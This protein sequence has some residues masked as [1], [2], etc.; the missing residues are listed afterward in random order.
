MSSPFVQ[1]IVVQSGGSTGPAPS[2]ALPAL[3][4]FFVPGLGQL[5]QGRFLAGIF[6]FVLNIIAAI[7]MLAVV[8]FVLLPLV[9]LLCIVDAAKYKPR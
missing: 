3:A 4:N 1:T 6:W 5:I 2:Q 8:G 9:W 7:S